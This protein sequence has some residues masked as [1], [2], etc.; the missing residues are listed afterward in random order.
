MSWSSSALLFKGAP[1]FLLARS[2]A[3]LSASGFRSRRPWGAGLLVLAA[4]WPSWLLAQTADQAWQLLRQGQTAQAEAAFAALIASSS[5]DPDPWLGRGLARSRLQ[6]W[7]LALQDLEKAVALAPAY[8]DA[9]SALADVYRWSD[10]PAAAADAYGR[11]AALRPAD[12]QPQVL[13]ARSLLAIGDLQ[14][15]GLAVQRARELGAADADLPRLQSAPP[16]PLDAKRVAAAGLTAPQAMGSPR[17]AEAD[18]TAAPGDRWAL[19]VSG[20]ATRQAAGHAQDHGLTLRHYTPW[21]SIAL[22]QLRLHRFGGWDQ[23]WALDAYPRLW[24]G[25]YANLRYQRAASPDLY[26]ARSWRAELY[27]NVGGGWEVSASRDALDFSSAVRIDGVS[28]GKYW[29]NFYARWRHQQVRSDNSSGRGNRFVL[30][31]YYRGDAD[32]YLEANASR[33]RS[34]D[35]ASAQLQTG[36]SNARGLAWTWWPQPGWG[37]KLGWSESRDTEVY[38]QRARDITLGLTRRW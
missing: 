31:Y 13:R 25:A 35:F 16:E 32:H 4:L 26:P 21:G 34:D 11:L 2:S 10:R 27:Q 19:T 3:L 9:W 28:L 36:R 5:T 6:Q 18:A 12:A 22:E 15:A 1:L 33:G 14:A 29:G 8:A 17:Q 37:F 7:D 30:R 24:S 38:G 20:G 23:A